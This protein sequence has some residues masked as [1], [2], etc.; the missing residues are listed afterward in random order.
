MEKTSIVKAIYQAILKIRAGHNRP[1]AENIS[2]AAAKSLGL[3]KEQVKEHLE[4]LV[5][6][7]AVYI[8][9]TTKGDDSYFIMDVNKLGVW[10]DKEPDGDCFHSDSSDMENDELELGL[11]DV[12]EEG[13][14]VSPSR[15]RGTG[16]ERSELTIFLDL[17]SKLT[18][19]VR[20]LNV[21]LADS[22]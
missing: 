13:C 14:P 7:G 5:E 17:L 18:D 6:T 9:Q 8:S 22:C 11:D 16:S 10:D 20:D 1:H 12:M 2:K 4:S 3:T 19:D 15:N 21:K